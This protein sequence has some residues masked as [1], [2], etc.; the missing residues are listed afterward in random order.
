MAPRTR[1]RRR[2]TPHPVRKPMASA[3]RVSLFER[4]IRVRL[5]SA[6]VEIL[7]EMAQVLSEGQVDGEGYY[8]STMVTID[9]SRAARLVS[10]GCDEA[11][12]RRVEELI[13]IDDRIRERARAL[14]A[15]EAE[16]LAGRSIGRPHIDLRHR[17]TGTHLHLDMDVEANPERM[18]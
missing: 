3:R 1:P 16:R 13:L 8:G 5:S 6:A 2:A 17:R 11:C 10:D 12:A 14:A 9:L 7:F 15:R 18:P 4:E